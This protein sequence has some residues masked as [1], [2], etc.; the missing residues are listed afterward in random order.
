MEF[1]V[2][3]LEIITNDAFDDRVVDQFRTKTPKIVAIEI[4]SAV[5]E[6]HAMKH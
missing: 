1:R 4:T 6:A 5:Q 3:T 2:A